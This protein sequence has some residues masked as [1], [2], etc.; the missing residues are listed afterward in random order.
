MGSFMDILDSFNEFQEENNDGDNLARFFGVIKHF[1][2]DFDLKY[3]L[4]KTIEDFFNYSWAND[5]NLAF[6]TESDILML[7]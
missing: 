6:K 5:R 4:K 1:N 7:Q 3:E 2:K